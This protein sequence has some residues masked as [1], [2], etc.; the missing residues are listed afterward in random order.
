MPEEDP[1]GETREGYLMPEPHA[2]VDPDYSFQGGLDDYP[3]EW[4]ELDPRGQVRLRP[5]RKSQLATKFRVGA[6]GQTSSEGRVAW[7]L[8]GKFRLCPACLDQPVVQGRKI[9][10]LAGLSAEGRSSATTL[11]ISSALRAMHAPETH[12]NA[13][14]QKVLAFTDNRQDAALQAGNFNDTLFV[15]LLR[16]AILAAVGAQDPMDW[17]TRILAVACSLLWDSPRSTANGVKNGLPILQPWISLTNAE[18][19]L[20]RVIAYRVWAIQRRGWRFTNP[21][22]EDLGLIR[23]SYAG[24]EELAADGD[25]FREASSVLRSASPQQR[26]ESLTLILEGLRQALAI[27]TESLEPTE[28]ESLAN[29]SG[30]VLRDPWRISRKGEREAAVLLVDVPRRQTNNRDETSILR[31][32]PLSALGRKLKKRWE[33]RLGGKMK[34]AD[35]T[36]ALRKCLRSP[37]NMAWFE[38]SPRFTT[39]MAGDSNRALWCSSRRMADRTDAS[40]MSILS[41][42]ARL[43]PTNSSPEAA[44]SSGSKVGSTPHRSPR[45]FA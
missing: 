12:I 16:A 31:A 22:L 21:N 27:A 20:G 28:I 30:S 39:R 32:G 43:S 9:N 29:S 7:F 10:K 33:T 8:P 44:A 15:M 5:S 14:K 35:Y 40:P 4:K 45:S 17:R 36:T 2:V 25:A 11:L 34:A 38:R 3:D 26:Q 19:I 24:V 23:A 18:R 1:N 37:R 13:D 42:S 6:D 41:Q